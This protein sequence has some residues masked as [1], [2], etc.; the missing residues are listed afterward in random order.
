VRLLFDT[1]TFIWW[2]NEPSRLSPTA[3][4]L[5]SDPDNDLVLSV[6]SLWEMQIKKQLGKLELRLPLDDIVRH[7]QS[8]NGII[9][10]PVS[11]AEILALDDLPMAHKDPF[12][13]LLAAQALTEDAV[14]VSGDPIFAS[15][16]VRVAW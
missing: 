3:L 6:A 5:C 1:H 11:Q 13:R 10:L 9:V 15:Y 7:Q 16:P 2:D 14:L 8:T 4:S 12:D